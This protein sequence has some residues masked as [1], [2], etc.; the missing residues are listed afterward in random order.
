MGIVNFFIV[1]F[2]IALFA[3]ALLFIFY[4]LYNK[5]D[6]K[7]EANFIIDSLIKQDDIWERTAIIEVVEKYCQ[8]KYDFFCEFPP[9]YN[10]EMGWDNFEKCPLEILEERLNSL[11]SKPHIIEYNVSKQSNLMSRLNL[12]WHFE[13]VSV[14]IFNE[15]NKDD[16]CV[17]NVWYYA[18]DYGG[19]YQNI[20]QNHYFLCRKQ[21]NT[22]LVEEIN[23]SRFMPIENHVK[24]PDLINLISKRNKKIFLF[25]SFL[26][27]YFSLIFALLLQNVYFI[28][29]GLFIGILILISRWIYKFT[30]KVFFKN[31]KDLYNWERIY[32]LS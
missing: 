5:G 16:F 18:H 1:A 26:L 25:N 15:L 11:R 20:K 24:H 29:V 8:I 3:Y 19:G 9:D 17:V 10:E 6:K 31:D 30:L 28:A 22:W 12:P 23:Y 27:L 21:R 14:Y 7:A 4:F 13:V 2:I 32:K